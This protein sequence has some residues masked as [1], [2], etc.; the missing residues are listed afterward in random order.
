MTYD[1]TY[2]VYDDAE[3]KSIEASIKA[4]SEQTVQV[5]LGRFGDAIDERVQSL[6]ETSEKLLSNE[7][8]EQAFSTSCTS[9]EVM[10]RFM[11]VRPLVQGAFL[12]EEWVEILTD[13]IGSGRAVDDRQLLQK[14]LAQWGID[15]NKFFMNK[16]K[17]L[18]D[19][20]RNTMI[21]LRNGIVHAGEK[22]DRRDASE[23][24]SAAKVFRNTV[25]KSIEERLG[26]T[27]ETTGCW[28]RISY[29]E[30][31]VADGTYRKGGAYFESENP[32]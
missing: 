7:F 3:C 29:E 12:S 21:P 19:Y 26:F 32:F 16:D 4:R 1:L 2:E 11:V 17:S 14:L 13:R 27:L 18:W 10:I 22:V 30:G 15:I 5:Y 24:V 6:L 25:I 9:I 20:I 28:C 8:D 31:T 23:A